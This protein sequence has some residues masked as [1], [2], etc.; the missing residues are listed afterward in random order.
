MEWLRANIHRH[1]RKYLPAELVDKATGEPLT[2]RCYL[3]YLTTKYGDIYGL[4]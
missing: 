3:D 1:G 4:A 2:S